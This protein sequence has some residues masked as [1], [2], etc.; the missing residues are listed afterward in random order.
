MLLGMEV[1]LGP[2][3]FVFDGHPATQEKKAHPRPVFGPCLLWPDGWVNQDATWYGGKPWPRRRCVRWARSSPLKVAQHP[4]FGSCLLWPKGWMDEDTI[5][6][7]SRPW[8]RPHCIRRAPSSLQEG[9]S[10]S[11]SFRP[12]SVVAM[13]ARLSYC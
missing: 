1:G 11:P 4:V 5:W 3:D 8:P 12:M 13:V 9:H 6:Y 2:G 7:R 10:S